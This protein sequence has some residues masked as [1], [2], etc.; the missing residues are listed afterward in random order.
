MNEL[1][2]SQVSNIGSEIQN[3]RTSEASKLSGRG[4]VQRIDIAG[5]GNLV[6]KQYLRGGLLR[7]IIER[8]YLAFGT[9]RPEWE[10]A[11]LVEAKNLGI[12]CPEPVAFIYTKGGIFYQAWLLTREI[13]DAVSLAILSESDDER[14][15]Q[16]L[17]ALSEQIVTLIENRLFHVDLHPGNVVLDP[18]NKPYLS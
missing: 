9:P 2:A 17:K 8:S 14:A 7:Y 1:S 4:K 11:K 18:H 13:P 3:S 10:F 6:L 5:L 15:R 12:N 16:A